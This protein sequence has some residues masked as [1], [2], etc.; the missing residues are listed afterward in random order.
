MRVFCGHVISLTH[1]C[2]YLFIPSIQSLEAKVYNCPKFVGLP[3]LIKA[4]VPESP[5]ILAPDIDVNK[6]KLNIYLTIYTLGRR[7]TYNPLR[8]KKAA[9]KALR[10]HYEYR[11][12][13]QL[14]KLTPSK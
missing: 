6:G 3:D 8:I 10:I 13:M 11:R 12:Q 2:D 14:Q 9:Q 5:F 7:F 1:K 4:N